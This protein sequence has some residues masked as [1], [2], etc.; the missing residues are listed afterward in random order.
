MKTSKA[1]A[2]IALLIAIIPIMGLQCPATPYMVYGWV[3]DSTGS[4]VNDTTVTITNLDT[5]KA[6]PANTSANSNYYQLILANGTDVNA[7]EVLQFDVTSPDGKQFKVFNHTVNEAEVNNGGL[8]NYNITLEEAPETPF[9]IY[10]WVFYE[11]DSECLG[12]TVNVT[13]TN[14]SMHWLAETNA[15]SNYYQLILDTTN[16]SA[17]NVLEFNATDGT[18]FNVT[19]HTVTQ[20]NITDGGL[21]NFNLTLLIPEAAP[22]VKSVEV[23]PDPVMMNPCSNGDTPITVNATVSD[24]NGVTDIK[25]VNITGFNPSISGI[26]LPIEMSKIEDINSTT[27][28][29]QA[30]VE[31]PCCTPADTYTVTVEAKDATDATNTSTG[32]FTAEGTTALSINFDKVSFDGDPGSNNN[33][34]TANITTGEPIANVTSDGNAPIDIGV[35]ASNLT[36]TGE[37]DIDGNNMEADVDGLGWNVVKPEYIWDTNLACLDNTSVTFRLDI[38]IGTPQGDY[39]GTITLTATTC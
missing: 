6:F 34:G 12:P 9:I 31:L 28:K 20:E 26:S 17:G 8:F 11:D 18:Q 1:L 2:V 25:N 32:T 24:P 15:S 27:A 30:T 23:T 5:G 10:G 4:P 13:N 22:V 38:P 21:F 35:F 39:S 16:I 3:N 14:T 7:S 29:Y 33:S 19:N 36:K 37:P